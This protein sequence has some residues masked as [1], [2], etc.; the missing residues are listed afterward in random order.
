MSQTRVA[1]AQVPSPLEIKPAEPQ[2]LPV[3]TVGRQTP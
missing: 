2:P 1:Q 3:G